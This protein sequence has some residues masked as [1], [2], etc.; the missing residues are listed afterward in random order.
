MAVTN[1]SHPAAPVPT[2]VE[3]AK[4]DDMAAKL[5]GMGYMV[6]S[7]LTISGMNGSVQHLS[8]S[9]HVFEIAF[10]RQLLGAIFLLAAALPKGLHHLRTRRIGAH[11]VRSVLNIGAMLTYFI[12]LS[13]EPLAKVVS[14]SLTVPLF[15]SLIAIVFLREPASPRRMIALGVG[16]VG[17]V[18]ILN[19]AAPSLSFGALM[20]LTS[21]ILWAVA[22]NI[23]KSLARTESSVTISLY[24]ALLMAPMAA[25]AAVWVWQ[26]PTL[27]QLAWLVAIGVFGSIAQLCLS[28]AFREAD[29]T[30]VLPIDF[31]KVVWA[32]L[33]GY[34]AFAQV[35][36]F[37]I[38]VGAPIVFAAVFYNAW[39]ERRASP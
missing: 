16:F 10:F 33:I 36:E 31:T 19:P 2:P 14:L 21:N 7:T 27:V 8:H 18:V 13:Q 22:L 6:G 15:A 12:G 24:A 11:F 20:V 3:E 35:P 37:W 4:P 5:R 17:A 9:M 34:F 30:L 1:P 38:F 29:V 28:Q 32:S 23:I 39:I 26:T 25:V